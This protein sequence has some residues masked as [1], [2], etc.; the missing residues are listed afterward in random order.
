[1]PDKSQNAP[2]DPDLFSDTLTNLEWSELQSRARR[3]YGLRILVFNVM[4][5]AFLLGVFSNLS[6]AS[7]LPKAFV[8]LASLLLALKGSKAVIAVISLQLGGLSPQVIQAL[9]IP[10]AVAFAAE[11]HGLI[12]P[13]VGEPLYAALCGAFFAYFAAGSLVALKSGAVG[14]MVLH[15]MD[16]RKTRLARR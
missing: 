8:I 2:D 7:F 12:S 15:E 1:V 10:G 13:S 9:A 5:A 4:A 11:S 16:K 3:Y 6:G 14:P